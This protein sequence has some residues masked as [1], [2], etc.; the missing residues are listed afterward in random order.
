MHAPRTTRARGQRGVA[1]LL[2]VL[3]LLVAGTYVVLKGLNVAA[4]HRLDD[5]DAT[6]AAALK[7]AKQVVIGYAVNTPA[8]TPAGLGPG[9]LPCPDLTGDGT[10]A[11]GCALSGNSMTGWLPYKEL[12]SDDLKDGSGARLWYALD[13]AYRYHLAGA[14]INSDTVSALGVDADSDIVAVV[15]APGAALAGQDRDTTATIADFLE[16]ENA[17]TGDAQFTRNGVG[18][19]NDTLI[20]ITRAELMAAVER[21]VLADARNALVA[22][23]QA[24]GGFPWASPFSNPATSSY[25]PIPGT[26]A[27][28]LPIHIDNAGVDD[29]FAASF[30]LA[31]N[32]PS[33][34]TLSSGAMPQ[35]TCMRNSDCYDDDVDIDYDFSSAALTFTNGVCVWTTAESFDC[36]GTQAVAVAVAGGAALIRTYDVVLNL[37]AVNPTIVSPSAT[38]PR[39]R[40]TSVS[41]ATLPSGATVTI[42]IDDTL[43]GTPRGSRSFTLSGAATV[44]RFSITGVPFYLGDDQDQVSQPNRSPAAL[45]R[46]FSANDWQQFLY[47]AFAAGEAIGATGCTPATDCLSVVWDRP[48]TFPDVTVDDARGV[49]LIA[50]SDLDLSSPRPLNNLGEYFEGENA[51]LNDVYARAPATPTMN[52][53]LRIL[54]PNE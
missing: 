27:G 20:A 38:T 49:A 48:G 29:N 18:D 7:L 46:W 5:P 21:R 14:I 4:R 45:P 31:W 40:E 34:G 32:V 17:S 1:L 53:Q 24:Y 30:T 25:T 54:D 41:N 42:N 6:T 35:D 22:Y 19:F 51:D 33:G 13:E 39:M 37:P 15:I 52:D 11:G 12:G 36:R 10:A 16:D 43:D 28:Q 47:Y 44:Q 50:G 2:S 8:L 23:Q 3:L 9:R 26:L